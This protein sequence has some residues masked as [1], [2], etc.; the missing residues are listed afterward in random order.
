LS[1]RC[2]S[3]RGR[4]AKKW[5]DTCDKWLASADEDEEAR[6]F[7]RLVVQRLDKLG[8]PAALYAL[9]GEL[10][11]EPGM[12]EAYARAVANYAKYVQANSERLP[13]REWMLAE[14]LIEEEDAA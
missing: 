1:W 6:L 8:H 9:A 12:D 3:A 14:G 5:G 7:D 10:L 13:A 11:A 2:F 4:P